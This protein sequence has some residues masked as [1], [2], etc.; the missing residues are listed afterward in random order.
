[1]W[2]YPILFSSILLPGGQTHLQQLLFELLQLRQVELTEQVGYWVQVFSF[3][4]CSI[5]S[6]HLGHR[7]AAVQVAVAAV[8]VF[9]VGAGQD[10]AAGHAGPVGSVGVLG[11]LEALD[12][13]DG[14]CQVGSGSVHAVAQAEV[15]GQLLPQ[16]V[17]LL[18]L[19]L[20]GVQGLLQLTF[21]DVFQAQGVFQLT[22]QQHCLLLHHFDFVFQ[23]FILNL[24]EKHRKKNIYPEPNLML[25]MGYANAWPFCWRPQTCG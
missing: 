15:V 14:E 12:A 7:G 22:V 8:A 2:D 18:A 19:A 11:E 6:V 23:P 13:G 4:A 3:P 1:M 10:G 9:S 16:V 21:R 20:Q 17:L 5:L 24:R 25:R